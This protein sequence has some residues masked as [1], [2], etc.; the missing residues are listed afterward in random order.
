MIALYGGLG[1]DH[2]SLSSRDLASCC[3]RD[4]SLLFVRMSMPRREAL[5]LHLESRIGSLVLRPQPVTS[6]SCLR[7]EHWLGPH[8]SGYLPTLSADADANSGC[9]SLQLLG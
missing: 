7:L 6:S 8:H 2:C 5:P 4:A 1:L 9:A 3:D